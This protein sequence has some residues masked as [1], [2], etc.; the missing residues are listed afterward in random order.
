MIVAVCYDHVW[1][2]STQELIGVTDKIQFIVVVDYIKSKEPVFQCDT[3]KYRLYT[4]VQVAIILLRACP[5]NRCLNLANQI[6]QKEP[7]NKSTTYLF[8]YKVMPMPMHIMHTH[9]LV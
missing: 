8:A 1:C 5:D 7:L 6:A 2:A 4:E 9:A 3:C